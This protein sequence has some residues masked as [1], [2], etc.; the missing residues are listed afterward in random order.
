MKSGKVLLGLLGG[1]AAGALLG[2]LFAPDKGDRTRRKIV[3][4]GNDFADGLKEKYD[5]YVE[6]ITEKYENTRQQAEEFISKRKNMDG[7]KETTNSM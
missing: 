6:G 5:D 3:D 2:I 4:K 7:K 1:I